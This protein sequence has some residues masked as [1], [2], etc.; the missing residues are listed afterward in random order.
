MYYG[1]SSTLDKQ[2]IATGDA[3]T[4]TKEV[5]GVPIPKHLQY[6]SEKALLSLMYIFRG[7]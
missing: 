5:N 1:G 3:M 2:G 4:K 7:K 6:L